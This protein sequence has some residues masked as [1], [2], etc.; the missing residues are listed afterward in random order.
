[1]LNLRVDLNAGL[2]SPE[3]TSSSVRF[4]SSFIEKFDT[5][6]LELQCQFDCNETHVWIGERP[7]PIGGHNADRLETYSSI[8]EYEGIGVVLNDR[9]GETVINLSRTV[10]GSSPLY[11]M[12]E[13][14]ILTISWDLQAVVMARRNRVPDIEACRRFLQ[15]GL[16]LAR[17]QII[18]GVMMLWPG[19]QLTA[20][21]TDLKFHEQGDLPIALPSYL[22]DEAH[23]TEAF[24]EIIAEQISL[25]V[26]RSNGVMLE[27]S[28]GLDST[29]IA[30][31]AHRVRPDLSCYGLIHEG[32][33][34]AQQQ[35]R[36][37]ELVRLLGLSDHEFP[38]F[39]HPPIAALSEDECQISPLDDNHRLSCGRAIDS[40][41]SR[42]TDLILTGIGGDELFI[43]QTFYRQEWEVR[44]N[45]SRSSILGSVGRADMFL[46]RG[47]WPCNPFAA[48][49]IVNFCRQLPSA[50][51]KDRLLEVLTLA[52][53]GLSDGFLFPRYAEH[54][55]NVLIREASLLDFD[56]ELKE[57]ILGDY[58][59]ADVYLLLAQ[60]REAM[61]SNF[62]SEQAFRLW[63]L[64]KLERILKRYVS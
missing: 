55:G 27:V 13:E 45:V 46:R 51:R 16:T 7:D 12:L 60:A 2:I 18:A 53:S 25:N 5:V 31:A 6:H 50:L 35:R 61:R 29:C 24:L 28:G 56:E 20:T 64:I 37:G 11:V 38:S 14:G 63:R 59:V 32:A 41:H 26:Q 48:L 9:G 34:G 3:I 22:T 10:L 49:G 58:G 40:H 19:E 36:R 47:I 8:T 4:G 30:L 21:H 1:M 57:S 15:H 62:S 52:R 44:G 33:M 39:R 42:H 43:D 23:V 17:P 54:Y